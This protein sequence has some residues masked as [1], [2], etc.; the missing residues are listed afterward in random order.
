ME[1]QDRKR[2]VI[3]EA[4][5]KRFAQHGLAKTTMTE[6]A[7]DLSLSKALLYY[8]FPDKINLY[9]E[10][11]VHL[12]KMIGHDI[13]LGLADISGSKEALDYYLTLRHEYLKKY[14]NVFESLRKPLGEL[15][16]ILLEVLQSAQLTETEQ[17]SIAIQKQENRMDHAEAASILYDA[18]VG[19]RIPV[20]HSQMTYQLDPEV[21][22]N[23]LSRQKKLGEI[24]LKGIKA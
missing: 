20:F 13:Q 14:Y 12:I 8:Y 9:A 4:A 6:I 15:P 17:I 22:E 16:S 1:N 23:L 7:A 24:F 11:L 18:F 5:I 3:I 19:M 10:V 21:F 2:E